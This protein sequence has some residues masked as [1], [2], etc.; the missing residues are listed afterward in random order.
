VHVA[1]L[2]GSQA[3]PE[4][5]VHERGHPAHL[6]TQRLV[7]HLD[8]QRAAAQHGVAVLAHVAQGRVA[9]RA[10]LGIEL[11]PLLLRLLLG[12]DLLLCHRAVESSPRG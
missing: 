6:V 4:R 7:E 2:R 8:R 1:E 5:L 11:P 12:G 10:R 9:A 3:D